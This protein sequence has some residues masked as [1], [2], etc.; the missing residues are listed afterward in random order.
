MAARADGESGSEEEMEVDDEDQEEE[1]VL[2]GKGKGKDKEPAS[3]FAR[4]AA[5]GTK[6]G[7]GMGKGKEKEV[8]KGIKY[9]PLEQQVLALK[10]ANPGVLLM[11]EVS[12]SCE[13]SMILCAPGADASVLPGWLQVQV[14]QRGRRRELISWRETARNGEELMSDFFADCESTTWDRALPL[15]AHDGRLDPE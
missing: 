9:T 1:E 13:G 11:I 2:H 7:G 4:F 14:L 6:P 10:K 12:P 3:Q 15:S 8:T 5:K